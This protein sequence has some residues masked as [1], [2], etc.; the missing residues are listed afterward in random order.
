MISEIAQVYPH[1]RYFGIDVYDK[2][3]ASA[4]KKYSHINFNV[5]SAQELPFKNNYFDLILF[6]ETIEHVENPAKCLKEIKRVLNK[7]G[8]LIVA[9][10]SGSLLF[11]VVWFVWENTKGRVWKNAHLHPFHHQELEQLIRKANFKINEKI[12]SF[13]GM[14]VT[15]ILTKKIRDSFSSKVPA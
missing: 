10:D 5:A 7:N 13:F 14:E 3:I 6:Y 2:A 15:F 9:M 11:K 1:A 12:F 4:K 8:N